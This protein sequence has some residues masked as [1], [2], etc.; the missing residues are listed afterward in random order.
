[1]INLQLNEG[2]M[3]FYKILSCVTF[4]F[5]EHIFKYILGSGES[6]LSIIDRKI[7]YH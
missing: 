6:E 3:T 5:I 2:E 7:H 1:M 4:L